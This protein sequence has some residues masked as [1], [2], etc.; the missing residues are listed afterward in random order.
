[1][2]AL[3]I[4]LFDRQP[5]P[6][7]GYNLPPARTWWTCPAWC[8]DC[9]GGGTYIT[10]VGHHAPEARIHEHTV[11]TTE[12]ADD[13]DGAPVKV[14]V[15]VQRADVDGEP[16]L[17]TDVILRIGDEDGFVLDRAQRHALALA[18]LR[19]DDLDDTEAAA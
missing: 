11:H 6:A 13:V 10:S 2:T 4:G 12:V 15:V 8:S 17:G 14:A 1:M 7:G 16:T 3:V 18:L 19:A 5:I 9:T